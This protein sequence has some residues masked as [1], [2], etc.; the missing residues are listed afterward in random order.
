MFIADHGRINPGLGDGTM[1]LRM[2]GDGANA[3]CDPRSWRMA[4][5]DGERIVVASAPSA[6]RQQRR[7]NRRTGG[8]STAGGSMPAPLPSTLET[9]R[10]QIFPTLT[11]AEI[12]RLQ[13]YGSVRSYAAGSL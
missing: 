7:S 6:P 11:A 2:R 10:D 1:V 13:R 3:L 12:Q 8:S 4:A 5:L 9:R